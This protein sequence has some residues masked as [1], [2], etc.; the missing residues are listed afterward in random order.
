M[1]RKG[2]RK[3]QEETEPA[4]RSRHQPN[5][6]AAASD[7]VNI[8]LKPKTGRLHAKF[9]LRA[10]RAR[11]KPPAGLLWLQRS[12]NHVSCQSWPKIRARHSPCATF[13]SLLAYCKL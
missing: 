8:G 1:T 5:A 10:A 13:R 12:A 2:E 7:G 4:G 6:P 9:R 11:A 3:Q